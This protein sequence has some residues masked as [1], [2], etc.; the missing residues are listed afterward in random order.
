[1]TRQM[2]YTCWI[3]VGTPVVWA[4]IATLLDSPVLLASGGWYAMFG[5]FLAAWATLV[6][7]AILLIFCLI[8]TV[9]LPLTLL[10][11]AGVRWARSLVSA[12]EH[13]LL[14]KKSLFHTEGYVSEEDDQTVWDGVFAE[15]MSRRSPAIDKA[16]TIA[17]LGAVPIAVTIILVVLKSFG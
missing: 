11:N 5:N 15:S 3:V 12:L 14:P 9:F 4:A 2:R 10:A 7:I 13:T 6:T 1:M 8:L 16:C 17:Q